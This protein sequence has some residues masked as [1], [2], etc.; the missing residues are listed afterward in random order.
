MHSE[1]PFVYKVPVTPSQFVG[2]ERVLSLIFGQLRNPNRANIAVY[3]PL[4][5]GKTSLLNYIADPEVAARHG[6][7]PTQFLLCKIDC[8]SLGDFTPAHFW[9]R[10]LHHTAR[11]TEGSLHAFIEG[12]LAQDEVDFEDIQDL[13]DEL[14]RS[15]KVLIAILD[16]FECVIQTHSEA[17]ERQTRHFLGMLSALGRRAPRVFSMVIATEAPLSELDDDLEL[18]RGSPFATVFIGQGLPP[19]TRDETDLLFDRVLDKTD[20]HFDPAE[21]DFLYSLTGGHPALLQRA[22]AAMFE[23]KR[24]GLSGKAIQALVVEAVNDGQEQGNGDAP[25]EGGLWMDEDAGT[26]WVD[27][28]R[29]DDLTAKEFSLLRFLYQNAGRVCTKDEIWKAVWPEYPQ[30]MADYPIQKIIS[31]LRHKIEPMPHRPRYIVTVRGRGYR[32]VK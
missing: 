14:E 31:R 2:R 3:G 30:G 32:L 8:Q 1:N 19:F 27:G 12:L 21:R 13:L 7:D 28:N 22:A 29:I 9:K 26:V 10:L 17:A 4:G 11:L 25:R 20:V 6:L 23:G 24:R 15:G 16:E 18:W 5:V